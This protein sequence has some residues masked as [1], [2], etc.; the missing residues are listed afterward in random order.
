MN[1]HDF[2]TLVLQD[3]DDGEEEFWSRD[4]IGLY[5]EDGYALLCRRTKCLFDMDYIEN[6]P[7]VANY[8]SD[9]EFELAKQI[10]NLILTGKRTFTREIDR[11]FTEA[12]AVGPA[13]LS[14]HAQIALLPSDIPKTNPT[15]QLPRDFVD[16]Q[17]VVHDEETLYAE[18]SLGLAR[19][20]DNRYEFQT[21]DTDWFTVDKDG[22]FT[23]RRYPTG[24]GA[25][26]YTV[27]DGWWGLETLDDDYTGEVIGDWGGMTYD[28]EQFP[29]RGPWGSPTRLHP[30]LDNTRVELI[31][32]GQE[33][34]SHDFE[35]PDS[36]IKYVNYWARY[37]AYKREGPGQNLKLADHF[38][39]RFEMGVATLTKRTQQVQ[40]EHTGRIGHGPSRGVVPAQ[41]IH[42]PY[43]YGRS[44]RR[45][46]RY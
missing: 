11:N 4:E 12:G 41:Q 35:I 26:P 18:Y 39:G 44:V 30:D 36:H 21:G 43:N 15:G 10:P 17:R 3:L 2:V 29:M 9:E 14:T 5:G 8:S 23:L 25:A 33:L 31:R 28:P 40:S 42:L 27:V 46:G 32:L 6:L 37:R 22:L 38:E 20:W 34:G 7:A 19:E 16:I 1:R 45:R 13:G 24:D